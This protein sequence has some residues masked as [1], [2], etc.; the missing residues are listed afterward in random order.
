[1]GACEA[2]E[3]EE[4]DDDELA[5]GAWR[6]SWSVARKAMVLRALAVNLVPDDSAVDAMKMLRTGELTGTCVD[7]VLRREGMSKLDITL[8]NLDNGKAGPN[9][10]LGLWLGA[11]EIDPFVD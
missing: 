2:K 6:G 1:M 8:R 11:G 3:A 7:D 9:T 4:D 5:G 10:K